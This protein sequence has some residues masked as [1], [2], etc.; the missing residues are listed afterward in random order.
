MAVLYAEDLQK[1]ADGYRQRVAEGQTR[2]AYC[3]R[4][5]GPA[6]RKRARNAAANR[7][8][9]NTCMNSTLEGPHLNMK[10]R[11]TIATHVLVLKYFN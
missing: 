9:Q 2:L 3:A 11:G 1:L 10:S 7:A 6:A 4:P 5:V 8:N